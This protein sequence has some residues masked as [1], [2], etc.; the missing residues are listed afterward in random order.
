MIDLVFEKF[1]SIK[2]LKRGCTIT[3]KLD[4]TNAQV[5]FNEEGGILCGSRNRVI[6]PDDDNYGF[7]AWA[8]E[9]KEE[10]FELLGKGR[11]FGEWWGQGI[12]RRYGMDRKMFSLFNT[13]RWANDDPA[14]LLAVDGLG[15]VPILYQGEFDTLAIDQTMTKLFDNGSYATEHEYRNPE[16]IVIWHDALRSLSKITFDHDET[17][18]PEGVG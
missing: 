7:A 4:G 15:T 1:P 13:A 2:R 14:K 8:Y 16:G 6:T 17:G 5:L 11:H 3:E 12:Q 10:M 18:K 9:R